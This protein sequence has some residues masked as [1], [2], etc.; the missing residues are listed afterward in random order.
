MFV[1][2]FY[3]N[4]FRECTYVLYK[5]RAHACVIIDCGASDERERE[6]LAKF[7]HENELRPVA[8]L[9]THTHPDHICGMEWLEST[10]GI[11]STIFPEEGPLHLNSDS[12]AEATPSDHDR[13]FP[14]CTV[15]RTPGH[16]EDCVCYIFAPQHGESEG[17]V[18]FSGDTL[19]QESVGRTDLPG[20]D[21]SLLLRSLQRLM[22]LPDDVTIYPG[23]GY[24][25]TIAHERRYNPY[26]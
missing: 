13:E 10:Y 5:E 9:V 25:T 22:T 7:I 23:H 19:F 16:K 1:K 11:S 26:L 21:M 6:R 17:T 18:L 14:P 3:F 15:L 2:T 12:P 8:H 4:P 24:P 20:G